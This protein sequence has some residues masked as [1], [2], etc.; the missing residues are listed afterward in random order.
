M[1]FIHV[2]LEVP[3]VNKR[4]LVHCCQDVLIRQQ[5]HDNVYDSVN[6]SR[7]LVIWNISNIGT[8]YM[9]NCN[10]TDQLPSHKMITS[11]SLV[12]CFEIYIMF[13]S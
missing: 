3:H 11:I 7:N 12:T 13:E 9:D 8:L 2:P 6:S 4:E 5:P 1:I 10:F